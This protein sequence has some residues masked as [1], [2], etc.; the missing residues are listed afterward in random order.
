MLRLGVLLR[1]GLGLALVV[2]PVMVLHIADRARLLRFAGRPR[3]GGVAA[4]IH[5]AAVR[6]LAGALVGL[7]V[8]SPIAPVV[9]R[10]GAVVALA[11]PAVGRRLAGGSFGFGVG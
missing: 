1:S 5:R 9:L 11:I 3:L 2:R 6:R 4:L 10:L 7:L 8:R